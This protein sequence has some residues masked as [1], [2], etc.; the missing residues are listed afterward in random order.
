MNWKEEIIINLKKT[1][2]IK[3]M[4]SI[5]I[6]EKISELKEEIRVTPELKGI[7]IKNSAGNNVTVN[8]K[9]INITFN[10]ILEIIVSEYKVKPLEITQEHVNCAVEDII[11]KNLIL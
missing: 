6:N 9:E 4:I 10:V 3:S 7:D 5:A 11:L 8:L 2:E 1:T